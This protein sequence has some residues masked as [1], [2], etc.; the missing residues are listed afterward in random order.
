L[1]GSEFKASSA[2]LPQF[3]SFAASYKTPC[4]FMA[5]AAGNQIFQ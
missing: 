1:K 2:L 5:N 4:F 3:H